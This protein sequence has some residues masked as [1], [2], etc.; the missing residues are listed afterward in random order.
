[1]EYDPAQFRGAAAYYLRGRPP[2]SAELADVLT[3]EVDDVVANY[4]SMSYA[5]P[6]LF[7]ERL[8]GFVADLRALLGEASPSG[9]FWDWPGD[10]QIW[11]AMRH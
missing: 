9:R 8:D 1:M 5:A 7:G 2:Y 11:I 10:T 6:H 3:T 4:L